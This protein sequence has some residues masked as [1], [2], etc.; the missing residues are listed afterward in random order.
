MKPRRHSVKDIRLAAQGDAGALQLLCHACGVELLGIAWS[1]HPIAIRRRTRVVCAQVGP[2]ERAYILKRLQRHQADVDDDAIV[3]A[4][5]TEI[6]YKGLALISELVRN[7]SQTGSFAGSPPASPDAADPEDCLYVADHW[8]RW[9][10]PLL[11]IEN[12]RLIDGA[13]D[14][15]ASRPGR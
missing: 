2:E 8:L 11:D 10:T 9:S 6:E 12:G 3:N 7:P 13:H 4:A 15:A 5:M 1:A 14:V